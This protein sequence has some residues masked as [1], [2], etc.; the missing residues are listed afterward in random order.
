MIWSKPSTASNLSPCQGL[1]TVVGAGQIVSARAFLA[2]LSKSS[3]SIRGGVLMAHVNG[4]RQDNAMAN[5]S[6]GRH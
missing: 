6:G 3:T 2:A 4:A 1:D 5:F